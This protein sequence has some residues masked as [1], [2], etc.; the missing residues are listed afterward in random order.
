MPNNPLPF[1]FDMKMR[2][3][4]CKCLGVL[5]AWFVV[6][7]LGAEDTAK[8]PATSP[9]ASAEAADPIRS[10]SKLQPVPGWQTIRFDQLP[11]PKIRPKWFSYRFDAGKE[12]FL[13]YVPKT[14]RA[15]QP[16]GIF[17]WIH[18]ED[19]LEAPKNFEPL[20][21]EFRLIALTA[22]GCG[23]TQWPEK[24]VG[25]LVSAALE[26]AKTLT[27]DPKRRILSG[28]SGGGRSAALGGFVH[29]EFWSGVISWCGGNYYEDYPAAGQ[30]DMV[31]YG[32]N[33]Y[34]PDAVTPSHV[35]AARKNV[36]FVLLTGPQD[37]NL[38][39]SRDVEAAMKNDG[40][41]VLLIEEPGLGHAIGS[42]RSMRK[43]LDFVL[44]A[45]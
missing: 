3:T 10:N 17:G 20:F 13:I 7:L 5:S 2:I 26:I 42:E 37:F 33:H 19:N 27:V 16:C 23:N 35:S 39:E 14:Y 15:D 32:I 22:E 9:G 1:L 11:A 30:P 36:R 4:A 31:R 40:L 12:K 43:A 38:D 34:S 18:P 6:A 41:R 28:L 25:L 21:D 44:S 8:A 24:R 45:R 29:P